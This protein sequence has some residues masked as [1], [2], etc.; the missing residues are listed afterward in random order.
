MALETL[1]RYLA[2][3]QVKEQWKARGRRPLE[4]DPV[5]LAKAANAYLRENRWRLREEAREILNRI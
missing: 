2:K 3:K 4:I 1:S 5:E